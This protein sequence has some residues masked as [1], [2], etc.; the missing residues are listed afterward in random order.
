MTFPVKCSQ[1]LEDFIKKHRTTCLAHSM[2]KKVVNSL[3]L[4]TTVLS[5]VMFTAEVKFHMNCN[6][7]LLT[8]F[9]AL[10]CVYHTTH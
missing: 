9:C 3:I 1:T 7:T 4:V 5:R 8:N 6:T 2:R 10:H